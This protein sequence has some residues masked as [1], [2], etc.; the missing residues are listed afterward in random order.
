MSKTN[1]IVNGDF[2]KGTIGGLPDGWELVNP[3]PALKP[4]FRLTDKGQLTATGNGRRECFGFLKQNIKLE[5]NK[6]YKMCVRLRA[7]GVDDLNHVAVHG[8]YGSE[9]GFFTAG[10]LSYH[11]EGDWI[12]G[13][14][15]FNGPK[16]DKEAPV[17]IYFRHSPHG[18]I[19]WDE[20]S[21]TEAEPVPLRLVKVAVSWG[22]HDMPFWDKWLDVAGMKHVDVAL[23]PEVFNKVSEQDAEPLDGPTRQFLAKKAR[24]WRMHVAG[25]FYEKRG[26]LTLNACPLYDREGNLLGT[27]NKNQ[28][29]DP[30]EDLGVTPGV[31]MPV[32]QTDFGKVGIM[33]CYDS[34]YPEP[35]RLL[36]YKGAELI[37]FPS[38]AYYA[39]LMHARAADNGVWIAAS[40]LDTRAGIWDSSGIQAG[41]F[42][43]DPSHWTETSIIAFERDERNCMLIATLDLNQ[44]YSPHY[45]GG[46]MWSAPGGR[47]CRQ[48]IIEPLE[49]Q[50]VTEARRWLEE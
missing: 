25:C 15:H 17:R 6:A 10:I 36:A 32:F 24:R 29:F 48:T 14:S 12:V 22:N 27:Y 5:A 46:P 13:E 49:E 30:E 50:I 43:R 23:L 37:L 8:I 16:E 11:K 4:D 18:K 1:L 3:N 19:I 33:I 45:A 31:E 47:R 7:E 2:S 38:A 40:S 34:W 20:I 28:V 39:G 21:L 44:H 42:T 35:T 9:G 41:E 26:D